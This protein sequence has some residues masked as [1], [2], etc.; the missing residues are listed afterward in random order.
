MKAPFQVPEFS[1]RRLL[2]SLL[3]CVLTV[4]ASAILQGQ[5]YNIL[6]NFNQGQAG[7]SPMAGVT[8]DAGGNLYG[9]TT[10]G[11]SM[12]GQC[13]YRSG[14]GAV[15]KLVHRG[16]GWIMM[17]L[18][19]FHDGQ[20]G[21]DPWARVVFGP[22][23][24]LYGTTYSGGGSGCNQGYDIGCGTVFNLRPPAHPCV[25][26]SC[27]WN[28]TVL[29]RFTGG[30]DGA[31][32]GVGDLIFDQS[33]NIYG[34]TTAGGSNGEGTVYKLTRSGGTWTEGVL[35]NFNGPQDGGRIP[36]GGVILVNGNLY[37][38]TMCS[39]FESMCIGGMVYELSPSGSNF[40]SLTSFSG[41]SF[42]QASLTPNGHGSFYGTTVSGGNGT[43]EDQFEDNFGCGVVFHGAADG[44]FGDFPNPNPNAGLS[45]PSA[46]VSVDAAGNI[47][48]TTT[49]DG[50]YSSGNVFRLTFD[51][52]NWTYLT[53]H[54]FGQVNNDGHLPL[55][56]VAVGSDG[57]LYGTTYRGGNSQGCNGCGVIWE[58]SPSQGTH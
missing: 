16:A 21:A 43:C 54:D 19:M 22:D 40:H 28:E 35:H 39:G 5:T 32:P 57:T 56:N 18:Y 55:G 6:F 33:G 7:S 47:Y 17:P 3:V 29:Y 38:T 26:I 50:A 42:S 13:Y 1:S 14:C 8:L 9:T 45:G 51:G 58:L 11:G 4:I 53:L 52:S 12:A 15:Y 46:P 31:N 27:P 20:D 23:G 30:E 2:P 34:T 10:Y 41:W 49:A 25:S 24:S 44:A 37:G 48:G 36:W